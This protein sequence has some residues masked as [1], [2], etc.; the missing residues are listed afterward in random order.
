MTILTQLA[1]R[2]RSVTLLVI[3]LLLVAGVYTYRSLEQELFPELEFPNITVFTV[4]P[5]ANPE[6]VE[7]EV[8]EP[9]EEAV[10]GMDGLKEIESTSSE[11][12]SEVLLTFEFGRDME[13]AQRT[14]QNN[15]NSLSFPDDVTDPVVSRINNNTFPVM[16]L[17]VI[18][19]R[20]IPSLQRVLDDQILP[21]IEGVDGVFQ[22]TTIGRV[23]ERVTVTVDT[24]KLQDLGLSMSHVGR[25]LRENNASF[26]GGDL[27]QGG[28]NFRIRA[29]HQF[30]SLEDIRNLT[31]GFEPA[32]VASPGPPVGDG[33]HRGE[34][35]V[36]LRDVAE[37]EVGTAESSRISRA[38]G[39]PSLNLVII[40]DPD[41]NTVDVTSAVLARTEQLGNLPPDIEILTLQ[42][43]GPEVEKQLSSL[44]RE[45]TTGFLFAIGAVYVFLFTRR[46]GI[47]RGGVIA[48]RPTVI[49]GV[50]IPLS[51]VSGIL[52]M[53]L[54]GLSLNF[55]SLSGLAIAVGRV[56]DDSIVVL[57]NMYR[58]L[59]RGEDRI[60][61][62]LD[63]TREVGAAIVSSTLTTVVVFLPLGFIQGLVG[64][65]F[66]P[67][68][69]SVSFALVASTL[70]ALTAVP[71]LGVTL[72]REGDFPADTETTG[73]G[74]TVL[75]RIYTPL[76]RFALR[77]KALVLILAAAV[78]AS[79]LLWL[80][81]VPITLFPTAAP[82]TL[83]INLEM[84]VGTAISRSY[85]EVLEVEKVLEDFRRRGYVEVYNS[86]IGRLANEFGV[87]TAGGGA[88]QAGF[89]AKLTPDVPEDIAD[90]VRAA[91]PVKRDVELAVEA[92]TGGPAGDPLEIKITGNR[93]EDI[94]M[95]ARDIVREV[96]KIDG[97]INVESDLAAG[98]DEVTIEVDPWAAAEYDLTA[99][100]VGRQVNQFILGAKAGEV[101]LDE[102][103]LDLVIRGRP[104]DADNLEELKDLVIEG[105]RGTVK[106]GS[107]S[108]IGIEQG[109]VTISRIDLDRA[110]AVRGDITAED[111][112]A[113]GAEVNRVLAGMDLP[114]GVAVKTGGIF[115]QINEGFQDIFTAMAIGI[116]LVYLVMVACLGSLR[117]PFI[118][119]L[120]LPLAVVGALGALGVSDRAL[121]LSAL[122]G[123]LLLIGVVVTNAIV[124]IT[125][126]EQLREQ[127]MGV[128]AALIEGGRTRLRP[129]LMT[130]FTTT[131][132]LLP[133]ALSADD[134]GGIIGAELATVVIGGLISS[135]FLT[136]IVVPVVY[137]IMH[138]TIPAMLNFLG[139][140]P[141]RVSSGVRSRL[142]GHSGADA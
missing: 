28:T 18:G 41:A 119:V 139:S 137:M 61:A 134:D 35:R 95:A 14:I 79:S 110:A 56:V 108:R 46:L 83:T 39:K 96:A 33:S 116:L 8:T 67:F 136:L 13:E 48:L 132:A 106:L 31:V 140:L 50:S 91:L 115:Q 125:F 90:R 57:E 135:T 85:P 118:V 138:S 109:A 23:S 30:G 69:M 100:E 88:H 68:A 113:I 77:F 7:R 86:S 122:M 107:I 9:I 114:P 75:Q 1:L 70:V 24:A 25:A 82:V 34:R 15:I 78:V 131:L 11:N 58:H 93:F 64:E 62:A 120:S 43:D 20:D 22:V 112:Q 97:V 71:V 84:P 117:D 63:G 66:T 44:L 53:G 89:F 49:I 142:P 127:G 42:D 59:Q 52:V 54:A 12:V 40:K 4:Y 38:N 92:Q 51:I 98:R 129:I 101:E 133:L 94:S 55:M 47:L 80:L 126:V 76:L 16:Q 141:G 2:R 111:T 65:F 103:T 123:L 29:I 21:V 60:Q 72:L 124:L 36:L 102:L 128:Y 6:T 37:V 26:P 10:E 45:G 17:S 73:R 99:A 130:A 3:I 121:G 81:V 74:G 32:P 87:E 19:D 104:Q 105:P 27:D 5:N